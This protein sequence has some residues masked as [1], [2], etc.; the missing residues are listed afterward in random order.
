MDDS[1][2]YPVDEFIALNKSI[3][4]VLQ[5]HMIAVRI[6]VSKTFYDELQKQIPFIKNTG[7]TIN[8]FH[9]IP[10]EIVDDPL[11]P[12]YVI[13]YEYKPLDLSIYPTVGEEMAST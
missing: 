7:A 8:I 5:D 11:A 9:G 1:A 6:T 2:V 12:G 4:T 3:A 10:F 13:E